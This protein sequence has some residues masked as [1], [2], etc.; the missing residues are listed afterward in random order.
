MAQQRTGTESTKRVAVLSDAH[1]TPPGHPEHAT[2]LA[3]FGEALR[4]AQGADVDLILMPGDMT[5]NGC[6]AEFQELAEITRHVAI[7]VCFAPGNHE[8]GD[9]KL[10]TGLVPSA[11]RIEAYE[12][13]MGPSFSA[14]NVAGVRLVTVNATLLGSGLALERDQWRML[15]EEATTATALRR[16]LMLHY[17]LFLEDPEEPGGTYWTIEPEPRRRLLQLLDA[18]G[19]QLVV[20]GHLHQPLLRHWNGTPLVGAPALAFGLP[21]ATMPE[22]WLLVELAATGMCRCSTHVVGDAST[23]RFPSLEQD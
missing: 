13:A 15:E 10:P 20:T 5:D 6:D 1:L 3:Q 11:E 21:P 4:A 22:G 17:P 2:R 9:K 19:F 12:R 16:V 18:G 8:V 7:P 23:R 14:V